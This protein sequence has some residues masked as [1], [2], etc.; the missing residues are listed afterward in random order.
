[1]DLIKVTKIF[2]KMINKDFQNENDLKL[3]MHLLDLVLDRFKK[4]S[5]LPGK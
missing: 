3:L 2:K 1:M 4:T 5:K